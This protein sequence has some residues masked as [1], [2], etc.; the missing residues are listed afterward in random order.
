MI[1][2]VLTAVF[3]TSVIIGLGLICLTAG[4]SDANAIESTSMGTQLLTGLGSLIFGTLGLRLT[5]PIR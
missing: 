4:A 2:K 3:F 5:N 1:R